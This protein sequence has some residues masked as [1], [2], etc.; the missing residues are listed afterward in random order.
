MK[1]TSKDLLVATVNQYSNDTFC[2]ELLNFFGK[3]SNMRFNRLALIHGIYNG[4][5]HSKTHLINQA[6]N[7]LTDA[8]LI[9][10]TVENGI[11]LYN[12][13]GEKKMRKI[14]CQYAGLDLQQRQQLLREKTNRATAV[15]IER[16]D[17]KL[18][19]GILRYQPIGLAAN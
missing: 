15:K 11:T 13:T 2:L 1:T 16:K 7:K 9:Y 14:V 12:L 8:Q 18:T 4:D 17:K 6:L 3:F 19:G 5:A 10:T